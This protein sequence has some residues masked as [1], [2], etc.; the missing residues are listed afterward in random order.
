MFLSLQKLNDSENV[1][2][3]F[4]ALWQA[5]VFFSSIQTQTCKKDDQIPKF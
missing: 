4:V 2:Q 1:Q 3:N 5:N